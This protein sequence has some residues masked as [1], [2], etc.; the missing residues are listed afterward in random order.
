MFHRAKNDTVSSESNAVENSLEKQ[1]NAPQ[2]NNNPTQ[3][4]NKEIKPMNAHNANTEN[5]DD[6]AKENQTTE[7]A[8]TRVDIPNNNFTR[9]PAQA[10]GQVS[11]PAYPGSYPGST[12]GSNYSM[13]STGSDSDRK[14]M[15]GKGITLSGEI[16]ECE[17][18]IV[19][20]TV[21][22][23]L[24]GGN[25]LDISESGAFYGTV[26]IVEANIAGKF[27]GDITVSGRLT[28]QS[29]GQISG[30]ISYKELAVE[31]GASVDGTIAPIGSANANKV[32]TKRTGSKST[33][34]STDNSAELPFSG[35][36]SAA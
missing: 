14:L 24:K 23:T 31:V 35:A 34:A 6:K 18:L 12:S 27:E 21:E 22:A 7:N 36:K 20:G 10:T 30:T 25:V 29:T 15:I 16:E 13:S 3:P 32:S 4:I 11:R 5:K 33:K 8:Q 1:E 17:H 19:D 28:V 2:T 9:T 26:E